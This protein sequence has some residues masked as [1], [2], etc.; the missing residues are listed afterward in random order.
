MKYCSNCGTMSPDD[1]KFCVECGAKFMVKGQ[2]PVTAS[3]SQQKASTSDAEIQRLKRENA[4][5]KQKEKDEE[6][7]KTGAR[8]FKIIGWVIVIILALKFCG[9]SSSRSNTYSSVGSSSTSTISSSTTTKTKEKSV[10][11]VPMSAD[12]QS[13]W[14]EYEKEML[15]Y[16]SQNYK[17]TGDNTYWAL[18]TIRDGYSDALK[19]NRLKSEKLNEYSRA[20]FYLY[21]TFEE[22]SNPYMIG[23]YGRQ[24]LQYL[25]AKP[26]NYTQKYK[27]QITITDLALYASLDSIFQDQCKVPTGKY[28]AYKKAL[29]YL[30]ASSFSYSGLYGQLQ[31]EGFTDDEAAFGVN[32]CGADWNEQAKL[33]AASY[34]K[35]MSFSKSGLIDQLEYEG[36]TYEQA[37]Y[38]VEQNGF[39]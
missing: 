11:D 28:N 13:E 27:N 30:N 38:G 16:V 8:W 15:Y 4:R 29:N 23:A 18:R 26:D 39:K 1:A 12:A 22:D 17:M 6:D 35:V 34:L 32:W 33:K 37:V 25:V 2:P 7:T 36:F 10:A 31:Y 24:A 20:I 14:D 5:L 3:P 9:G 21:S 19:V